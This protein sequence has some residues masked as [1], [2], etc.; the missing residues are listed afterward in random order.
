MRIYISALF[1]LF[2]PVI[3]HSQNALPVKY[4]DAVFAETI[5]QKDLSYA[6]AA[7]PG[8]KDKFYLFDLYEPKSDISV[9]RP[10]II[11]LHGGGFKFGSKKAAGIKLW[12]ETFAMRGYVCAGLNYPLGKISTLFKFSEFKNAAYQAVQTVEEAV[13][14]FKKNA[15]LYRIDTNRI[16][17]AGNSA[18]G[19]IAL[20]AA[21]TSPSQL[22]SYAGLPGDLLSNQTNPAG[23]AAVVNFWGGLLRIDWL[24]NAKVPIFSAYGS[25]D[26]LVNPDHKGT[27]TA[28]FGS[29]AIH[30]EAAIRRI[31]NQV[32]MYEGYSHELQKHFNPLF[33]VGKGTKERWT[34]AGQAAADFLYSQL[35]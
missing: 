3:S 12:C 30:R 15:G 2:V 4:K 10:L 20:Q 32:K 23:I 7:H 35:F 11:W 1:L 26:K 34:D 29:M 31:P 22:A 28:M 33:P 5:L 17:L 16:I 19:I 6:T 25:G 27:D 24:Q 21:Y 18:G 8:I 13:A 14:Y 9:T